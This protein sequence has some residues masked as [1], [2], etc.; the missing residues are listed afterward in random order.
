MRLE[1]L[2]RG[3]TSYQGVPGVISASD[4]RR[5]RVKVKTSGEPK[6]CGDGECAR[7][8]RSRSK[9]SPV[10]LFWWWEKSDE[11]MRRVER[12]R[13]GEASAFSRNLTELN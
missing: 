13:L 5:V 6:T 8:R 1:G 3:L 4:S 11:L 9:G 12:V 7:P 10:L 2:L